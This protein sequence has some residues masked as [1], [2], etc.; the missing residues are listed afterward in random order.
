MGTSDAT[1]LTNLRFADDI[2]LTGRSLTQVSGMLHIVQL[3]A[4]KCGLQLHPDKTKIISS[5]GRNQGRPKSRHMPIGDMRIEV[6]P[7]DVSLKYLGRQ[8][9][10]G[11]YHLVELRHRVRAGWTKFMEH[12]QEL[13]NKHYSLNDRLRLFD[14]VISPTVLYGSECW[15]LTQNMESFLKR[16]QRRMLRLILGQGRRRVQ[17]ERNDD[18]SSGTDVQSNMSNKTTGDER[19]EEDDRDDLEPW[20]DWIKRVTH[21]VEASLQRLKIKNWVQ[22]ARKRKWKWAA[23]LFC[24]LPENRWSKI[25]LEWNP[26]LHYDAP[27]PAARRRPARPAT[28]WFDEFAKL[29]QNI[30]D[31]DT[32]WNEIMRKPEFWKIYEDQFTSNSASS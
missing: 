4:T 30:S 8:I 16:T 3:E 32:S 21:S 10:F 1:R 15:T 11:D 13:T 31:P 9:L 29:L 14:A 24:A 17:P 18:A 28:R 2:L 19:L 12:K 5:T 26:Q 20:V 7:R 22:Q 25:A 6:L 23:R 27:R